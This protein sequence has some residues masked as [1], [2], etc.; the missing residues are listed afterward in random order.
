MHVGCGLYLA[1]VRALPLL[2]RTEEQEVA[3]RFW[4]GDEDA[5]RRLVEA[6]LRLVIRIAVAYAE[7]GL[8]VDDL[9]AE[10]NVALVRAA[11]GFRAGYGMEAAR[12]GELGRPNRAP[13][14]FASYAR[15]WVHGA[16]L[17]ALGRCRQVRVPTKMAARIGAMRRVREEVADA[18]GREATMEELGEAGVVSR[19]VLKLVAGAFPVMVSLEEAPDW[20]GGV[21]LMDSLPGEPGGGVAD[22]GVGAM[23]ERALSELDDRARGVLYRR[24]GLKGECCLTQEAVARGMGVRRQFVEQ[25]EK[26]ALSKLRKKVLNRLAETGEWVEDRVAG[27][28]GGRERRYDFCGLRNR[29]EMS[30]T[31]W[32]CSFDGW[33]RC[34]LVTDPC[35]YAPRG[36]LCTPPKSRCHLAKLIS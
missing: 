13:V 21:R 29:Q 17:T 11:R 30:F 22:D 24:D 27:G 34:S 36:R 19:G 28:V 2:S 3:A 25:I 26:G 4:E 10:G 16:I 12:T 7:R 6:N 18:H 8:G 1:W 23:L 15:R 35:G 20:N 5:G 32:A 9:I 31:V 33:V 14:K